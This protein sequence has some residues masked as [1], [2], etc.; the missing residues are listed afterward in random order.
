[1][2]LGKRN[3]EW[4]MKKKIFEI[5]VLSFS[6]G[7]FRPCQLFWNLRQAAMT[8]AFQI[9]FLFVCKVLT[10]SNSQNDHLLALLKQD[11][12]FSQFSW[13]HHLKQLLYGSPLLPKKEILTM[14]VWSYELKNIKIQMSAF[15]FLI[16]HQWKSSDNI[17]LCTTATKIEGCQKL[18]T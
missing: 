9:L 10:T 14:F 12:I 3:L 13:T 18:K 2:T 17:Y 7:W 8:S 15:I 1:M 11:T 16:P 5:E 4:I 6:D